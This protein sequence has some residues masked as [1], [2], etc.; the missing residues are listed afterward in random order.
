MDHTA[1]TV[2]IVEDNELNLKLFC[3]LLEAFN[4]RTV[5]TRDGTNALELAREHKP[6]LI[7][8]DI[9]LPRTSGLELTRWI[10]DDPEFESIPILAVTAFAMRADERRV[11]DAG[12]SAY[13]TKP[14]QIMP[15]INTVKGLIAEAAAA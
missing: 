11:R 12:C 10:K 4:F 13:M 1:D 2:L 8:M 5:V 9:Q 7:V 6:K 3:D 15:F 14:I